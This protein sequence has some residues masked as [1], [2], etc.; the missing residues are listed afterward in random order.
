MRYQGCS[1]LSTESPL[2]EGLG[3]GESGS[4]SI[5]TECRGLIATQYVLG[6]GAQPGEDTWLVTDA[7]LIFLESDVAGVVQR[8]V[9]RPEEFHPR[10]LA[11]PCVRLSP[12]TAP[13]RRTRR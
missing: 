1:T 9:S 11:E 3:S 12:H 8:V 13:I 2:E 6:E 5:L 10:P 7:G 4:V